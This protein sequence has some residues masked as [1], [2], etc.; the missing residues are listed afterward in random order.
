MGLLA[1]LV[2]V[3]VGIFLGH[4]WSFADPPNDIAGVVGHQS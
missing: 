2:G 3:A 4:R 1:L